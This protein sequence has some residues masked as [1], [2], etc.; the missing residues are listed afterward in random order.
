MS[1][2]HHKNS[3]FFNKNT[4]GRNHIQSRPTDWIH[5]TDEEHW[6]G[7]LTEVN[8]VN[9]QWNAYLE[10]YRP[11]LLKKFLEERRKARSINA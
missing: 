10:K 9:P 11:S 1:V 3:Q 8:R 4:E 6:E 5:A 7:M 2:K